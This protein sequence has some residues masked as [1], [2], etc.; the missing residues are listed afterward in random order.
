MIESSCLGRAGM[1]GTGGCADHDSACARGQGRTNA[2]AVNATP[3]ER[4]RTLFETMPQGV[5]YYAADGSVIG[6]NPAASEIVGMDVAAV[7]SWPVVPR[8]DTMRE[9]GTPFPRMPVVGGGGEKT[10]LPR[11]T[12]VPVRRRLRARPQAHRP[13]EAG[14]G[15]VILTYVPG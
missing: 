10:G 5:V 8:G 1:G 11:P 9:D 14:E 12:A 4:Y 13:K 3:A 15:S 6:V 2:S 7:P